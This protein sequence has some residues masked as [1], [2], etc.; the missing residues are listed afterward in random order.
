VATD[1][2]DRHSRPGKAEPLPERTPE[3]LAALEARNG[4]RQF[5]RMIALIVRERLR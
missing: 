4:L 1:G 5:D 3:E 2:S